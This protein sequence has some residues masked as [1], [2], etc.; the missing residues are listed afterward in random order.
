MAQNDP[1][2]PKAVNFNLDP[3]KVPVLAVDSYLIGS[4]ENA[5]TLNFGQ[6]VIESQQQN[7]VA[8]VSM[9]LAQ[10]KEFVQNLNDH[11]EKFER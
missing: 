9:S 5:I 2:D 8:R 6:A 10:A 11:I 4:N 7:I 3:A 1:A